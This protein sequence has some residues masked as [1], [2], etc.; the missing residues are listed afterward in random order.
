MMTS[1]GSAD[2]TV[3]ERLVRHYRRIAAGGVGL[4]MSEYVYID[5][6]RSKGSY[7]QLGIASDEHAIGLAWLAETI[8]A[9]GAKAGV[10]LV[11]TGRQRK[12]PAPPPKAPSVV[13]W[14]HGA[15]P[16][17]LSIVEI[18]EIVQAFGDAARRSALAGFDVI[19]IHAAHGYLISEFLS[20][21]TNRRVD[22]YGGSAVNRRRFLVEVITSVRTSTPGDVPIT[23]RINCTDYRDDGIPI[24]ETV[25]ACREIEAL[26]VSAVHVSGGD[27][28]TGYMQWSPMQIDHV[29]HRWAL[30]PISAAL[31]IPVIAS[32]SIVTPERAEELLSEG[33]ADFVAL[34][35]PLLADPDWPRKAREGRGVEIRPCVRCNDGCVERSFVQRL[36][37]ITCTVN[38]AAAGFAPT[39]A[40]VPL[41][42]AVVGAGPAGL[43]SAITL[44]DKGHDV[45]LYE[46]RLLGG[47]LNEATIDEYKADLRAYLQ[48]L[49]REARGRIR[50]SVLEEDAGQQAIE[51]RGYA[52]VVVATGGVRTALAVPVVG[53]P[54]V[55]D[56]L[57]LR[58][59]ECAGRSVAIVGADYAGVEAALRLKRDGAS[60]VAILAPGDGAPDGCEEMEA[61][62]YARL[63]ESAG[64]EVRAKWA[65]DRVEDGA[66]IAG[67]QRL[68]ADVI[69]VALGSVASAPLAR[70]LE[71]FGG[72]RVFTVGDADRAGKVFDAVHSGYMLARRI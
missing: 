29:P 26:G 22:A 50:I 63:L 47:L 38:P 69:G 10:Q 71:S 34:A 37:S 35:R 9:E 65:V 59:D 52:C 61:A 67:E 49:I 19:E 42:V 23:I 66:V 68:P 6:D 55:R 72:L 36:R 27:H 18:E 43:V 16:E 32:G 46:R 11:H 1:L 60:A 62:A 39:P 24:E 56:A 51:Q 7:C 17:E 57:E 3:S 8:Q 30:G 41:R 4:V 33:V 21:H 48:W 15:V 54:I 25:A 58:S 45:D 70:D 2:G 14:K 31:S 64:V 40:S 20:P 5:I 28:E 44:A 13:P 53:S 12:L